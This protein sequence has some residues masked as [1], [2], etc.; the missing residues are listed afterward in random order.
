M[1]DYSPIGSEGGIALPGGVDGLEAYGILRHRFLYS[2]G[3]SNGIG[4]GPDSA[5][6]NNSK[7]AFG[8]ISYKLGG[9]ALDGDGYVASEKNW[10]ERSLEIGVFGYRGDGRGMF[11][12]AE[13]ELEIEDSHFHRI[14]FDA[15]LFLQDFNLITSYVRGTDDLSTFAVED[16]EQSLQEE[17]DSSYDAWF[18]EGDYVVM[19]WL[20]GAVRYEWLKP[21]LDGA[22]TFKRIV[23]NVSAL[24]R[25]NVKAY[26]EYQR[27]LGDSDDYVLLTSVRF[28]F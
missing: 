24:I 10:R 4:P 21:A 7:D 22:P 2:G 1:L 16:E 9:L 14:G 18:I 8:R 27:N 11:F 5:D 19:P 20:H 25:A 26:V 23:P 12:P 28:L 17:G 6:V 3:I 13:E 15:N